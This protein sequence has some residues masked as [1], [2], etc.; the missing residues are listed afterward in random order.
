[1]VD[2]E[3]RFRRGVEMEDDRRVRSV[4]ESTG[5]F[6]SEEADIAVELVLERQK[7]GPESGYDFLFAE[8]GGD[9]AGYS[10]Y[11]RIPG[12]VSSY[13]IYWIVVRRDLQGRGIGKELMARTEALISRAGGTR[14][15]IETSSRVQYESTR[16][17]YGMCGYEAEA[18][19]K[20]F[21]AA[22]DGKVVYR[23][24]LAP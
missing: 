4:V 19:L 23:K 5:F 20:D 22:G 3:L 1:M 15:Y 18:V 6:S 24:V 2:T 8:L 14:V 12:T 10:C 7:A 21:Y 13:D 11:G 9:F 17:F 16:R